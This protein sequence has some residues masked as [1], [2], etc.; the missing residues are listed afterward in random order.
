MEAQW[1]FSASMNPSEFG[2]KMQVI[3]FAN[4]DV[5]FVFKRVGEKIV[6]RVLESEPVDLN[7]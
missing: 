7:T 6:I 2:R 1:I 4:P 3:L 5:N